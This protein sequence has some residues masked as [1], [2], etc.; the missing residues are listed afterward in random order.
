MLHTRF[1]T[2][3]DTLTLNQKIRNTQKQC[4]LFNKLLDKKIIKYKYD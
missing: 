1:D 2:R 3:Q 4:S